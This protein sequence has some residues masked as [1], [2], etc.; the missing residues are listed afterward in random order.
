MLFPQQ[1]QGVE[2]GA[3]NDTAAYELVLPVEGDGLAWR[4]G[5]LRGLEA[6]DSGVAAGME[7]GRRLGS[8]VANLC[9]YLDGTWRSAAGKADL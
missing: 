6:N 3:F 9:V 2:I 1:L 7:D 5:A 8:L 4:D